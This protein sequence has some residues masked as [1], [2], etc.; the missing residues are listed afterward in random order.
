MKKRPK[1]LF[2]A[3][4]AVRVTRCSLFFPRNGDRCLDDTPKGTGTV[5]TAPV[6]FF[7]VAVNVSFSFLQ[8]KGIG[9]RSSPAF[10]NIRPAI[11][12]HPSALT[13]APLLSDQ[14]LPMRCTPQLLFPAFLCHGH[15]SFL[16]VL[17]IGQRLTTTLAHAFVLRKIWGLVP[18]FLLRREGDSCAEA[19]E[20]PPP[21]PGD[22]GIVLDVKDFPA[23]RDERI[24]GFF[25]FDIRPEPGGDDLHHALIGITQQSFLPPSN[26]SRRALIAD[27]GGSFAIAFRLTSSSLSSERPRK[28]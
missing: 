14:P 5:F 24:S 2:L 21:N 18:V 7:L 10:N 4:R 20:V 6:L 8:T 12:N 27:G 13:T 17:P 15:Q 11:Y 9:V 22:R 26:R 1:G 28:S 23:I 3:D 16:P 19:D 25:G